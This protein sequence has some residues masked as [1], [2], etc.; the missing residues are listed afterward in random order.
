MLR[1]SIISAAS[2]AGTNEES[3][4]AP[5]RL[6]ILISGRG[7]NMLSIAD[8]CRNGVINATVD[9]VISNNPAA[10]GLQLA[11][12]R[13]IETHVLDH[14]KFTQ[15]RDFDLA[16]GQLLQRLSPDW[17]VLAGFMRILSTELVNSWQGRMLNIHP[18]LLPKYPGLDTHARA[19]AAG[20]SQHGASVHIV[21]PEL[22]A[23]PIIAQSVVPVL[24][25][26]TQETLA[27][28]VLAQEHELY[29][30]AIGLCIKEKRNAV[31][32]ISVKR[33]ET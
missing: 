15:R 30:R 33:M 2:P 10:E 18:S 21:T 27:A 19:L 7:S 32:S 26:D 14:H 20:D 1:L 11:E 4:A 6:A 12:N 31:Q 17:V 24:P 16:L 5:A 13:N 8:A 23:G 22:D 3:A 29:V 9:A 28:R 25:G